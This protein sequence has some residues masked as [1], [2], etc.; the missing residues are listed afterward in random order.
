[1]TLPQNLLTLLGVYEAAL[2]DGYPYHVDAAQALL[3]AGI[4]QYA[5]AEAT[6]ERE[7]CKAAIRAQIRGDG[8]QDTAP[9]ANALSAI[10]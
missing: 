1:M 2:A 4:E 6:A 9:L 10:G 8:I 5:K 3:M 7:R